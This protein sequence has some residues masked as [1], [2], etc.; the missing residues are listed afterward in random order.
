MTIVR[1]RLLMGSMRMAFLFCINSLAKGRTMPSKSKRKLW[2]IVA[3]LVRQP[4][5]SCC[6]LAYVLE[7]SHDSIRVLINALSS[8]SADTSLDPRREAL[9]DARPDDCRD[10][11]PE[12]MTTPRPYRPCAISSDLSAARSSSSSRVCHGST[13]KSGLLFVT[14]PAGM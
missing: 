4:W 8:P 2:A 13:L 6:R 11:E 14:P 12:V 7:T 5:T 9:N 10:V 1:N 3:K